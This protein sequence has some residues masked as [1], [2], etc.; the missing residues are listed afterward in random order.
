MAGGLSAHAH[1]KVPRCFV[2]PNSGSSAGNSLSGANVFSLPRYDI[3]M[4]KLSL[5]L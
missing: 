2:V 3:A 1:S 5:A 4:P